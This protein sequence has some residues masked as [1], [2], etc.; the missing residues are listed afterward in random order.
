MV[1]FLRCKYVANDRFVRML[2][3]PHPVDPKF[4][5]LPQLCEKEGTTLEPTF[6]V[7]VSSHIEMGR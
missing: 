7:I 2:T 4:E 1:D 3:D 6:P 5:M